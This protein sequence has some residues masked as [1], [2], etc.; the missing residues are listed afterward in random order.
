VLALAPIPAEILNYHHV[1]VYKVPLPVS[2]FFFVS[3]FLSF[4]VY[5][6]LSTYLAPR[7]IIKR[8]LVQFM[9]KK[10]ERSEYLRSW[11]WYARTHIHWHS[12]RAFVLALVS[13]VLS[14]A[15]STTTDDWRTWARRYRR[16]DAYNTLG[17]NLGRN[18]ADVR[19]DKQVI[20]SSASI[21]AA[22]RT[23]HPP[24]SCNKLPRCQCDRADI[25]LHGFLHEL[26]VN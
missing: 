14:V 11:Q 7:Q 10:S 4:S 25:P 13:T 23:K 2:F 18:L 24:T 9:K 5:I 8:S 6:Y 20:S 19:H 1:S 17:F 15:A 26:E 3:L 16:R 21:P 22:R 12:P